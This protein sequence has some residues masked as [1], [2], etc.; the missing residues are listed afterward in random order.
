[1]ESGCNECKILVQRSDKAWHFIILWFHP[2]KIYLLGPRL[3]VIILKQLSFSIQKWQSYIRLWPRY[4]FFFSALWFGI[5]SIIFENDMSKWRSPNRIFFPSKN[6]IS[7]S[8]YTCAYWSVSDCSFFC[9]W[10]F[11]IIEE[12]TYSESKMWNEELKNS[13]MFHQRIWTYL[14]FQEVAKQW[15][16]WEHL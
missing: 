12:E 14:Q 2:K 7:Y 6:D 15:Q 1:M 9:R 5:P 3:E 13:N 4:T 11:Q 8:W 10:R 16:L